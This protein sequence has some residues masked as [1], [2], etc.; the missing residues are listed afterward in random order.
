MT[1]AL[2]VTCYSNAQAERFHKVSRKL[3]VFCTG[4]ELTVHADEHLDPH[5][6]GGCPAFAL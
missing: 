3:D 5:R 1:A 2:A 6:C 4:G